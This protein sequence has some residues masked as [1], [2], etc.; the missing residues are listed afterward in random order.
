MRAMNMKK[1][2]SKTQLLLAT[3]VA[4]TLLLTPA[5]F[6]AAP[7][8]TGPTFNLTARP[9]YIS[10]PDG[11]AGTDEHGGYIRCAFELPVGSFA[12]V[13]LREIMKPDVARPTTDA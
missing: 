10:Q 6:A 9:A 8:I 11:S 3:V 4:L 2:I 7:G 12:T 13:V 5:A 1:A